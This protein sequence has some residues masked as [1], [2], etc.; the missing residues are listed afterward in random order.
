MRICFLNQAP[1]QSKAYETA[2]IEA[3][4]NSYDKV[5]V[6]EMNNGQMMTLLR[7][8]Y[9]IDAKGLLKVSGQPLKIIEVEKAILA[10]L[11]A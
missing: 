5:L 11:G 3:L 1:E 9:L 6:A 10:Q 4:L 2:K 8:Q 7:S